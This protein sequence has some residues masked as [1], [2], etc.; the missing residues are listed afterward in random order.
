VNKREPILASLTIMLP[1]FC[2]QMLKPPP[3]FVLHPHAISY[4]GFAAYSKGQE[5]PHVHAH[6]DRWA[7]PQQSGC[8]S[9]GSRL[10]TRFAE[11][12]YIFPINMHV[13]SEPLLVRA[14]MCH[15]HKLATCLS[16]LAGY[17]MH[18][19]LR[20]CI[21]DVSSCLCCTCHMPLHVCNGPPSFAVVARCGV[22]MR[23]DCAYNE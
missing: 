17:T 20:A 6:G 22:C 14:I 16:D 19:M 4:N 18:T 8:R 3:L 23:S 2:I 11:H 7:V 21:H 5:G 15:A 12:M 9:W 1:I 13:S 10:D